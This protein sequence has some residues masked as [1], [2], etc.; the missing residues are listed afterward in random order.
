MG[1]VNNAREWIS[2]ASRRRA[3]I[4]ALQDSLR[5]RPPA[6]LA[7]WRCDETH[8]RSARRKLAE[9]AAIDGGVLF[10]SRINWLL[11]DHLTLRPWAREA[12]LLSMADAPS[13]LEDDDRLEDYLRHLD[14]WGAGHVPQGE[15][16]LRGA[17]ACLIIEFYGPD[18]LPGERAAWI[19]CPDHPEGATRLTRAELFRATR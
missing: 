13:S 3:E 18:E 2:A 19:R 15:S 11:S 6:R 4:A 1:R 17:P 9:A 16:W 10:V 5:A 7:V 12:L 14:D 8:S